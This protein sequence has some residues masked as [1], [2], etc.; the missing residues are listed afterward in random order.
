MYNVKILIIKKRFVLLIHTQ[1]TED[2]I[3]AQHIFKLST[4]L[5]LTKQD[6]AP[7]SSSCLPTPPHSMWLDPANTAASQEVKHVSVFS[8][9]LKKNRNRMELTS[10]SYSRNIWKFLS[11]LRTGWEDRRWR[12]ISCTCTVFLN[13]ARYSLKK[14]TRSNYTREDY[15]LNARHCCER[16]SI[17][18][19][20][21]K[22]WK[23]TQD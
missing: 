3:E 9:C 23:I 13:T 14:T 20:V 11:L 5:S 12:K 19:I 2:R 4:Y 17:V 15:I 8:L 18:I 16:Y 1:S 7:S 6:V 10:W 22:H 21:V